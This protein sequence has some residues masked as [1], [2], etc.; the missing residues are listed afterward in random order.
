MFSD[1]EVDSVGYAMVFFGYVSQPGVHD[2][3]L[4]G[5]LLLQT[6]RWV[7]TL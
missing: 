2:P 3:P 1:R 4:S 5:I 7:N 6:I